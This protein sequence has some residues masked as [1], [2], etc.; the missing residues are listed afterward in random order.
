MDRYH[1][2]TPDLRIVF[3]D[4]LHPHEEHDSQR[5]LP[6]IERL[7][8]EAHIINPPIV[9]PIGSSQFVILD[10]ANRCHS[11][12]TLGYPH[13]LVQVASY[14]SGQVE[15]QTWNHVVGSWD[16]QS[17]L[18][19][20]VSLPDVEMISGQHTQAIAHVLTRS[21]QIFALR[22]PVSSVHER[23]ATLRRVVSIYQQNATL[24]RTTLSELDE[25]W[26]LYADAIALVMFPH[27]LPADIIAAAKYQ[28]FLPPGISRHIVHGRALRVNYPIDRLK[29]EQVRLPEKN[30]ELHRW[31]QQKMAQRQIR[32]YAESTYQFDE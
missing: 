25:V 20:L 11:F 2:P 7:K 1:A 15:L 31:M 19:Q 26:P 29:D 3:A 27:Y 9:A 14:E 16:E 8:T 23:N 21:Q 17:F 10:G 32:Y 28:A 18:E 12:R 6:L 30:E 22:S 13:M 24:H 5:A 4:S